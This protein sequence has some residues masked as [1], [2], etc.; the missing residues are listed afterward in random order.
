MIAAPPQAIRLC[1]RWEGFH[2]VHPGTPGLAYP[3]LC[4]AGFWTIGYGHLCTKDHPPI[5]M[6]QAEA[7]LA[8][9]LEVAI[10][11]SLIHI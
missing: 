2:R 11:L 5:N 8:R 3:Y 1:K 10:A 7:H 6:E 4:P 9:D